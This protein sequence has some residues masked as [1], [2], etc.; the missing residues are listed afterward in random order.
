MKPTYGDE[1]FN[2]AMARGMRFFLDPKNSGPYEVNCV[3]GKDR[4][5]FVIA[6]LECLGGA[7][8][9]ELIEDYMITYYNYYYLTKN[10]PGYLLL[11]D[12]NLVSQMA[13]CFNV[14]ELTTCDLKASARPTWRNAG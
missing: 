6:V 13:Y 9:E 4:T 14:S 12:F 1:S 7:S 2:Q 3:E 10:D 8:Y 11:A 5:G